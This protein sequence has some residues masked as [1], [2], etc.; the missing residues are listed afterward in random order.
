[1]PGRDT[2]WAELSIWVA[3]RIGIV[4]ALALVLVESSVLIGR[5]SIWRYDAIWPWVDLLSDRDGTLLSARD[6]YW[7][8]LV[9][10]GRWLNF[11]LIDLIE[12]IPGWVHLIICLGCMGWFVGSV[13]IS[14]GSRRLTAACIAGL[15]LISPPFWGQLMWPG[16]SAP[17]LVLLAASPWIARRLPP[18]AFFTLMGA[19]FFGVLTW[20]YYLTILLYRDWFKSRRDALKII[21][22]WVGGFAFGFL[23]LKIMMYVFTG[24]GTIEIA[25]WRQPNPADSLSDL[26]LNAL[27]RVYYLS[28]LIE[29]FFPNVWVF[30]TFVAMF[31][32]RIQNEGLV[33]AYG[34]LVLAGLVV[35]SHFAATLPIGI[36]I[37]SHSLA[38]A[39]V[40]LIVLVLA[41]ATPRLMDR[42]LWVSAAAAIGVA[43]VDQL[44][45]DLDH[46]REVRAQWSA[47]LV[48]VVP[49]APE[50]F[51][52]IMLLRGDSADIHR[53]IAERTA[54]PAL[55]DADPNPYTF[56]PVAR[57]AGFPRAVICDGVP[58]EARGKR[59]DQAHEAMTTLPCRSV[60]GT[61][62]C[63]L[64]LDRESW[65]VVAV[66]AGRD[67]A[68]GVETDP[69][70]AGSPPEPQAPEPVLPQADAP[71][72]P[73]KIGDVAAPKAPAI[74]AAIMAHP[75]IRGGRS[76]PPSLPDTPH[77]TGSPQP[78]TA[79]D[80]S[81]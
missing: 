31:A 52:G 81:Q 29:A 32:I 26:G 28:G 72:Q 78:S 48:E 69:L 20:P 12:A 36:R 50:D 7:S 59:C 5:L 68:E 73:P 62:Y 60:D 61:G 9:S 64:G 27:T 63:F 46:Y 70:P 21:L 17:G 44:T 79:P 71:L 3:I 22:I 15:V 10:E 8:K 30:A 2:G 25:A 1:M 42:A 75:T 6:A 51:A 43:Q 49:G 76:S 16:T 58:D 66:A 53:Q 67:D 56:L 55:I 39:Y 40:G 37:D 74:G 19:L 34:M 23:V 35:L 4:A 57:A 47:R 54:P 13:S 41:Q 38:F 45:A 18:L 11:L 14:Y 77:S 65:A 80:Q 24:T 33:R